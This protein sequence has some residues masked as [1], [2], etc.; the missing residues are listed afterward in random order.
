MDQFRSHSSGP[1]TYFEQRH[2]IPGLSLGSRRRQRLPNQGGDDLPHRF[3]L[4][5]CH[6][7]GRAQYVVIDYQGSSHAH[8]L[9]SRIIHQML[10]LRQ[11]VTK[12]APAAI[13]CQLSANWRKFWTTIANPRVIRNQVWSSNLATG[14]PT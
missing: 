5:S 9:S 8:L 13:P 6:L 2:A 7:F 11:W 1:L 3:V 14:F 4:D 10:W 12:R